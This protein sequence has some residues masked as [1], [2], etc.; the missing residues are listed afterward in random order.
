MHCYLCP[1]ANRVISLLHL[2]VLNVHALIFM[3]FIGLL[4]AR[5]S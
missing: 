5:P 3:R 4:S 2:Y 1:L